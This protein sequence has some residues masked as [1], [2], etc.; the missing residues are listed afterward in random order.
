MRLKTAISLLV[1]VLLIPVLATAD[2]PDESGIVMR[3][4]DPVAYF[5]VDDTG[6]KSVVYG[7]DM[8]E[9][10]QD[11]IDFDLWQ[12]Q[13]MHLPVDD[14]VV[15][16][17]WNDA[18][19]TTVWP[20]GVFDCSLFQSVPPLASGEAKVL[21]TDNNLYGAETNR[22]NS[23]SISAHGVLLDA[24]DEEYIFQH[25]FHCIWKDDRFK[26]HSKIRLR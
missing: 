23:W 12:Y 18:A 15:T 25:N 8:Y 10:C 21:Y 14:V 11:I 19:Q 9:F 17:T 20:F 26:C 13:D 22:T 16:R 2:P 4:S 1:G 5:F 24:A 3:G 7:A 6:T